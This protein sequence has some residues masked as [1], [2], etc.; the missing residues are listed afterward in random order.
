[1]TA[2]T[3]DRRAAPRVSLRPLQEADA[4]RIRQWMREPD[5][6]RFTVLVPGPEYAVDGVATPEATERYIEQLLKDPRR[7]SFAILW[8]GQHVGN[9]GLKDYQHGRAEAECFIEIGV[10]HLRGQGIGR[11]S[12]DLLLEHCFDRLRL[13]GVRLGVF[14]FNVGAIR[15]YR[16]LGF[17]NTGRYGWHWCDGRYHEVMGMRLS[18]VAWERARLHGWRPRTLSWSRHS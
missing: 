3:L 17:S 18:R 4:D 13:E 16:G 7:L 10:T 12:M 1:M 6:V 9:I 11:K 15:L 14:D 8:D 2:H 5:L